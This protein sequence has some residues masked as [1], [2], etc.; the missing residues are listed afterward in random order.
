ML[1]L[2][3]V[4][5]LSGMPVAIQLQEWI[6]LVWMVGFVVAEWSVFVTSDIIC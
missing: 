3:I 4:V 1:I 5:T 2:S 6:L